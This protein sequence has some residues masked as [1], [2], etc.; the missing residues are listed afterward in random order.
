MLFV[1][2][3]L[4]NSLVLRISKTFLSTILLIINGLDFIS[5]NKTLIQKLCH[6]SKNST[7]IDRETDHQ[8]KSSGLLVFDL[9]HS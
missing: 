2:K 7:E 8:I 3:I 9:Y 6:F 5:T 1:I 4:L